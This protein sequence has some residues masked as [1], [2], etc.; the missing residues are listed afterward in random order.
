MTDVD[1]TCEYELNPNAP[2]TWDG[3][4]DDMCYVYGEDLENGVW[5]CPHDAEEGGDL[6]IFHTPPEDK[7]NE[8]VV[9]TLQ[10][11]LEK[12]RD[13]DNPETQR[14]TQQFIGAV[15]RGFDVRDTTLALVDDHE[16]DLRHAR[17][18]NRTNFTEATIEGD[19][20]F[21][22]ATFGGEADFASTFHRLAH[23]SGATFDGRTQF[24]STFYGRVRELGCQALARLPRASAILV[25]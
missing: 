24:A 18:T 7:T 16:L 14:R 9:M 3:E 4:E 12:A 5:A 20:N 11:A 8:D 15:F 23:F 25:P 1:G 10:E 21:K 17:F 22:G 2:K 6:C 13:A 19:S